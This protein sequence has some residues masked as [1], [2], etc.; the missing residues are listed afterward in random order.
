MS[1]APSSSSPG[2]LAACAPVSSIR[3]AVVTGGGGM[4]EPH[5]TEAMAPIPTRVAAQLGSLGKPMP[6]RRAL[7][8][9]WPLRA[10]GVK[11]GYDCESRGLPNR[12]IG[13][14]QSYAIGATPQYTR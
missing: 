7:V 14:F 4:L 6:R 10:E 11:G 9:P 12:R 2:W 13:A 3:A 1:W 5:A 8:V